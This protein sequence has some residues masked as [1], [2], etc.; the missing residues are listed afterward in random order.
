MATLISVNGSGG[1]MIGR[2]DARCY[3]AK[4]EPC[5]CICGGKNHGVGLHAAVENT[6]TRARELSES[7]SIVDAA[8]AILER[9]KD[10]GRAPTEATAVR[11][12]PPPPT[13]FE[14]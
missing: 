10:E 11:F 8:L 1:L 13:F 5:R 12:T 7:S 6:R 3:D 4:S 9:A 2:C 14:Q